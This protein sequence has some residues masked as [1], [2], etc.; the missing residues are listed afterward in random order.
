MV[1]ITKV[2]TFFFCSVYISA[3]VTVNIFFCILHLNALYGSATLWY[4]NHLV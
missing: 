1:V 2:D 3:T 4:R